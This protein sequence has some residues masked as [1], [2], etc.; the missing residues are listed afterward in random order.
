MESG[1]NVC[2]V[3]VWGGGVGVRKWECGEWT[4][5]Y[6]CNSDLLIRKGGL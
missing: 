1:E 5:W 3:C 2:V 4:H 6:E